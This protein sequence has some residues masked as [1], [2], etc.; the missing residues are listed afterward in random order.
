MVNYRNKTVRFDANYEKGKLSEEKY[1]PHLEDIFDCKLEHDGNQFASFDFYNDDIMVELKDRDE[2]LSLFEKNGQNCLQHTN[3]RQI[4]TL[5]FDYPKMEY[6]K[7]HRKERK[8]Y[9]VWRLKDDVYVVWR[10]N[11]KMVKNGMTKW[12]VEEKFGD[13]GKGYSQHRNIVNVY[14]ET[15]SIIYEMDPIEDYCDFT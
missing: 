8:F 6:F 5:W 10:V 15:C 4:Y 9:V 13:H 3:G 2:S 14:L 7:K 1:K 11:K 12:Y